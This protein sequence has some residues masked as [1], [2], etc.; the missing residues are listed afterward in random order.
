MWH[1]TTALASNE[2]GSLAYAPDITWTLR[3][4]SWTWHARSRKGLVEMLTADRGAGRLDPPPADTSTVPSGGVAVSVLLRAIAWRL[5][6][7]V[8][9]A[10][11]LARIVRQLQAVPV[12]IDGAT[13]FL[14][15]RRTFCTDLLLGARPEPLERALIRRLARQ[16]DV[17]L[18]AG[19]YFGLHTVLLSELVG[20]SGRVYAFEP[21]PAVLPCLT[22]TVGRI[23]N[24]TLLPV[25][26]GERQS[27]AS[28]F[29]PPEA[30]S[31]SFADWTSWPEASKRRYEVQVDCLDRLV[32][33]GLLALPDFFKCDVEGAEA[34]VFRGALTILE[35]ERAPFVLFELNAA[36]TAA[37]GLEANSAL[38]FLRNLR[39]PAYQFYSLHS[40]QGL[41]SLD[42]V[43]S[44]LMNVLAV[45][46]SR[47]GYLDRLFSR[48]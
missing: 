47:S 37:L 26:L 20:P 1:A 8:R 4:Y 23:H 15:L 30:S 27:S 17:A 44:A 31:A 21:S 29:V 40:E 3:H 28:L 11:A 45:P 34:L 32:G 13:V 16:G 18:D 22:K 19:A 46:M 42:A 33:E 25:A 43:P 14:D 10:Q 35:R 38:S 7:S 41:R 9:L 24:T 12:E 2:S 5:R 36:A 48:S 6:G 39:T